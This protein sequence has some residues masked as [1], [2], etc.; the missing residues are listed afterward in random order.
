MEL[1]LPRPLRTLTFVAAQ[2]LAVA[3]VVRAVIDGA[4]WQVA[5]G[6]L[7]G[8]LS[9]DAVTLLVHWVFDNYFSPSTP[10]VGRTVFYFRE[11]HVQ[12]MAMFERDV[13]D[14]NFE[15]ALFT[16]VWVLPCLALGAG[17]VGS[18]LIGWGSLLGVY[19][20]TIH[21]HA[22]L[23]R[24]GLLAWA[25]QR[26][27]LLVDKS[28]HDAH[29]RG[30]GVNYGLCAGWVDRIFDALRVLELLELVLF[31]LAGAVPV[32]PR[33]VATRRASRDRSA[34]GEP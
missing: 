11:H 12:P 25:L 15:N 2:A 34:G 6:V 33:L 30:E 17:P 21:R 29:H 32:H 13:I 8:H 4:W 16:L 27:A 1:A 28:H 24:P 3:L 20:T 23:E 22:H 10:V 9:V 7:L 5:L 19:I 31:K 14:N 18:A 26:S